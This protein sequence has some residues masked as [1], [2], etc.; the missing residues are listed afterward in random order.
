MQTSA[1]EPHPLKFRGALPPQ[2]PWFL[3]LAHLECREFASLY[4]NKH[5]FSNIDFEGAWYLLCYIGISYSWGCDLITCICD[6]VH[7][8]QLL[9]AQNE[10]N[11]CNIKAI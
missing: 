5:L 1:G 2:P 11:S 6:R 3:R 4:E 8:L 9:L 10:R 7:D